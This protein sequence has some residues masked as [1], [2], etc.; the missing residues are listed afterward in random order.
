ME[1]NLN[2]SQK[3]NL[4]NKINN[5]IE[6]IYTN[7]KRQ[8]IKKILFVIL[9]TL[10]TLSSIAQST[11]ATVSLFDGATLAG[12]EVVNKENE[13][14]WSVV[15]SVI[16][17]GDGISSI[18]VNTY[19]RTSDSYEDFEFRAL[20]RLTGDHSSGL[21]NSGI[22]Y[23]SI[24]EGNNIIGYQADIGKGYW[25]DIYDE[26]RRAK[27]IGGDLSTL[28]HLLKEDGWNSY[29]IRCIGNKHELY[30]NGV[31]TT[32][33]IE[34]DPEIPSKGVIGIQLHSGGNAKIEFKHIT[35]TRL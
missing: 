14:Y 35:I 16:T 7:K 30:I 26:H 9:T 29:I 24:I 31:K 33:Y 1:M 6:Q 34:K 22:Q 5:W 12:W 25:G 10:G 2:L 15:D 18:P 8:W 27:L 11:S 20:F 13:K 17:G 4:D 3:S 21:I 19:L 28:Q 23:R 32:E